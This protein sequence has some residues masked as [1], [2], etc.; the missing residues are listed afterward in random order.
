MQ[1]ECVGPCEIRWLFWA[2]WPSS[3]APRHHDLSVCRFLLSLQAEELAESCKA[4]TAQVDALKLQRSLS[5]AL[6]KRLKEELRL[7]DEQVGP[8]LSP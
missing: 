2:A 5:E 6:E 4:L 1:H 3:P 7:K 8:K